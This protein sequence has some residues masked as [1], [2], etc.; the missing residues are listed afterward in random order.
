MCYCGKEEHK[1]KFSSKRT[2][3]A[4]RETKTNGNVSLNIIKSHSE[5][6]RIHVGTHI[7]AI[8]ETSSDLQNK[9]S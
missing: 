6:E 8:D 7:D 5:Q 2:S 9:K 1:N 4:F 3:F